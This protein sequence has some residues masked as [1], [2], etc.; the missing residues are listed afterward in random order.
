MHTH[1]H[2]CPC[3]WVLFLRV[4]SFGRPF[5]ADP[6]FYSVLYLYGLIQSKKLRGPIDATINDEIQAAHSVM[7]EQSFMSAQPS[8]IP[9]PPRLL[10]MHQLYNEDAAINSL[11]EVLVR[12]Q[13]IDRRVTYVWSRNFNF[14]LRPL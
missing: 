13:D 3:E 10:V 5:P 9:K 2:T 8:P 4:S 6:S 12:G 7:W 14:V 11:M 1:T